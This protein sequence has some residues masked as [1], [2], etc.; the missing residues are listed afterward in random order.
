MKRVS[1]II[2]LF[3][4]LLG[5]VPTPEQE[6]VINK[7]DNYMEDQILTS[8]AHAEQT[9]TPVIFPDHWT[10][11]IPGP[12][13]T[14]IP[15][16]AEI[17]TSG[18]TSF[19]VRLVEPRVFELEELKVIVNK[20]IPSIEGYRIS[21]EYTSEDY[22]R[23][24]AALTRIGNQESAKEVFNEKQEKERI[25]EKDAFTFNPELPLSL[26][27][28]LVVLKESKTYDCAEV[29]ATEN[30]IQIKTHYEGMIH[31]ES[32]LSEDG[33][34][35]GE[36]PINVNPPMSKQSAQETADAFLSE[37]RIEGFAVG[38]AIKARYFDS[39]N[40]QEISQGWVLTY[41]KTYEYYPID[42]TKYDGL[43]G[44]VLKIDEDI[45]RP[46]IQSEQIQIY[47]DDKGVSS[48][49]WYYPMDTLKT[50]NE[51]VSLLSM[52]ELQNRIKQVFRLSLQWQE[53]SRPYYGQY[54][55]KKLI[56]TAT[57]QPRKNNV[58]QYWLL[59]TW[60]VVMEHHGMNTN[61]VINEEVAA[62]FMYGFNAIDGSMVRF[63]P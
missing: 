15:I 62:V 55:I 31:G 33:S 49:K 53:N 18:Q 47:V 23:I 43:N 52:E 13:D 11:L 5:C 28:N 57:I 29:T 16:D 35:E 14:S 20:M 58:N 19:P 36:G 24:V 38:D 44:N 63:T 2:L 9:F 60:V 17:I 45:F 37:L 50:I 61:H 54:R 8:A 10:D 12:F 48:F 22:D 59:P 56:L 41:V 26:S 34:Y 21:G 42:A 32:V 1:A 39:I 25:S 27:C 6:I 51:N 7:G 4:M 3:A 30:S 46:E 40:F